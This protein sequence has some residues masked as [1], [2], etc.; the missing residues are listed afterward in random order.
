MGSLLLVTGEDQAD[1][2]AWAQTDPYAQAG[3]FRQVPVFMAPPSRWSV[4]DIFEEG[5]LGH[6]WT[7]R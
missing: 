3:L 5:I 4:Q 6:F 7:F 2:E 1:V